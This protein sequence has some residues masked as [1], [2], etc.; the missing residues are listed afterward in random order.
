[1]TSITI[2]NLDDDL[3]IILQR[4]AKDRGHSLEEEAKE[5]LRSVLRK[6]LD[7]PLNLATAIERRFAGFGDFEIP[8]IVRDS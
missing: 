5:I 6:N 8:A 1:M 2:E 4:R 7:P 3:I